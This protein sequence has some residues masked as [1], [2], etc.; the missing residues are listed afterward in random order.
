MR[1]N[2][3]RNLSGVDLISFDSDSDCDSNAIAPARAVRRKVEYV[4]DVAELESETS[5]EE[6]NCFDDSAS[7]V[8]I[9][10]DSDSIGSSDND[11][12]EEQESQQQ[13]ITNYARREENSAKNWAEIRF[14]LRDAVIESECIPV[15]QQCSKCNSK[16]ADCRCIKCG[17]G[18]FFCQD[19]VVSIHQNI[20]VFHVIEQWKVSVCVCKVF[21]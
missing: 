1:R 21:F 18:N 8:S 5:R 15:G 13:T 9:E 17:M 6:L 7:L 4:I 10:F 16:S 12:G 20:C 2:I 14:K 19:C 11:S 3:K